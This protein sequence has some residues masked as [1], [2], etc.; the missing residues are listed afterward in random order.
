MKKTLV[1]IRH[2][3]SSWSNTLQSDFD[4]PLNERGE[5]DAPL[6]GERLKKY[7]LIADL[8]ISSSAKRTRQTA[9]RIAAA[10]G[11]DKNKISLEERLYHCFS[12]T[13]EELIHELNDKLNTVFI[14]AHNP[15]IT[16]FANELSDEFRTDN[17][18]TCGMV[19]ATIE[20]DRWAD[21][22]IAKKKVIL[23]EYPKKLYD[24]K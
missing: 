18:P 21:F 11:Y 16:D 22:S 6:M 12:K 19:A 24:N 7:D 14:I 20:A 4:R 10:I 2:A 8:I 5:H 17:I 13:F 1:L 3:K 9:K 23:F 15:G